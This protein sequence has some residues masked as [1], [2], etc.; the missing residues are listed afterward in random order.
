MAC[1]RLAAVVLAL[2]GTHASSAAAPRAQRAAARRRG[3]AHGRG[4]AESTFDLRSYMVDKLKKVEK[5][6]DE[7]IVEQ[8]LSARDHRVDAL[9]LLAGGADRPIMY[10]VRDAG[11]TEDAMATAVAIEMIHSMSLIHDDLPSMDDD[12]FRRGKPTNHKVAGTRERPASRSSRARGRSFL[13]PSLF[14]FLFLFLSRSRSLSRAQVYGEPVAILAGDALLSC[15]FEHVAKGT[16]KSV[17][18]ERVVEVIRRLGEAVGPVGLAGGQAMDIDCEGKPLGSVSLDELRWIHL[19]KTAK[20]LQVSCATGAV[21]AGASDKDVQAVSTYADDIGLAF[22]VA[23]DILDVTAT[24]E[25]LGKTAGKDLDADKTTYPKL[26][27]LDG[28]R[29]EARRLYKEAIDSLAPF[30]DR[31]TPLLAI[32]EYIV[33]REN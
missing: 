1:S 14:L 11:G 16:P 20:L 3:A 32:A 18:A 17:P 21:L 28:A 30:G 26:L 29:E 13:R 6:L 25:Q 12:D 19:H 15:A 8:C 4:R 7:S 9:P 33:E 22:Q 27:T 2:G 23:D 5:A 24:T 10:R 31:A